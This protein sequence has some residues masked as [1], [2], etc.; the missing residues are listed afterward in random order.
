VGSANQLLPRQHRTRKIR[1]IVIRTKVTNQRAR[2]SVEDIED[3]EDVGDTVVDTVYLKEGKVVEENVT[4]SHLTKRTILRT[5]GLSP[6]ITLR[7]VLTM[8]NMPSTGRKVITRQTIGDI[9]SIS[10]YA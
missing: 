3:V 9:R 8:I 7:I 2:T 10:Q 4:R 6:R 1:R 5:L